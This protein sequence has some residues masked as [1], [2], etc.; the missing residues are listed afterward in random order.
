MKAEIFPAQS[1]LNPIAEQRLILPKIYSWQQFET[2][3]QLTKATGLRLS[4]LDGWIE[5]MTVGEEHEYLKTM[6]G[7]LLESYLVAI[8]IDFVPA[9]S[10]TRRDQALGVSFEPDE[11]Y[12]LTEAKGQPDLAIEIIISSGSPAKLDKYAKFAIP[13][14][15]F[16][17]NSQIMVYQWQGENADDGYELSDRSGLLPELDLNLLTSCMQMDSRIRAVQTLLAGVEGK[18]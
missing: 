9:G 17:Q 2:L 8:G 6:L 16:W 13:E 10:A 4:Y 12:Y 3:E 7:F 15:W 1:H 18:S 11:S 5:F 14:V